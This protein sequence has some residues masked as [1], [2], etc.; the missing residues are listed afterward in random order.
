MIH[1][2]KFHVFEVNKDWL[3]QA[4]TVWKQFKQV[5]INI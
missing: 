5:E 2:R 1:M 3:S 4:M